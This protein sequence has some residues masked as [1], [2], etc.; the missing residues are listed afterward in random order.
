VT[1]T[2]L[3]I[4]LGVFAGVVALL[5][6]VFVATTGADDPRRVI[7]DWLLQF[8]LVLA[9]T[10]VISVVVRQSELSRV[11]RDA[12]AESLHELIR[13][14]DEAQM[15]ARLLSAH[16]TAKTYAEQITV[17]TAARG[18]LRRLAS[19]P[20]IRDDD[21]LYKSLM[22]MRGYLKKLVKEYQEK[23]LPVARQQRL[24]EATLTFRINKLAQSSAGS[25]PLLPDELKTVLPAGQAL[26]N[27]ELF[28]VLN[29]FR[30]TFKATPFRVAY[31]VAK[32]VMQRK[33]GLIPSTQ[34]EVAP[35]DQPG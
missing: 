9:G 27:P 32:P 10:G 23:Y 3:A 16:A 28:P 4:V 17:L 19:A 18:T 6:I 8:S 11:R 14:H 21:V 25:F 30:N 2:R 15:S 35:P 33:A 5:G 24:D 13:A 12:W 7:G 26:Q 20:G 1:L 31:E 22:G 34:R 29:E